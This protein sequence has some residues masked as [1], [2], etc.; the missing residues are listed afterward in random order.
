M[1]NK[2]DFSIEV[3]D[4]GRL[5]RIIMIHTTAASCTKFQRFNDRFCP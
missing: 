4:D 2:L 3:A 5:L 1:T